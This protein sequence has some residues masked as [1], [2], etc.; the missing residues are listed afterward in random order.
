MIDQLDEPESKMRLRLWII[1][2][3][4]TRETESELRVSSG[5]SL[6]QTLPRFDVLAACCPLN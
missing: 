1:L 6:R 5:R 3:R 2:L 4:L